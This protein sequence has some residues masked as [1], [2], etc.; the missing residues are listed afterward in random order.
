LSRSSWRTHQ[1]A[2]GAA[3]YYG[4]YYALY[5][6]KAHAALAPPPKEAAASGGAG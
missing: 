5:A 3:E 2:H 4:G 1:L 6:D